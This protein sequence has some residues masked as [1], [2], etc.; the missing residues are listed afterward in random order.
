VRSGGRLVGPAAMGWRRGFGGPFAGFVGLGSWKGSAGGVLSPDLV[1]WVERAGWVRPVRGR[2]ARR[3][4]GQTGN[5]VEVLVLVGS[6]IE[7]MGGYSVDSWLGDADTGVD[8]IA[9]TGGPVVA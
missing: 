1:G 9:G 3:R 8:K 6:G 5:R 4:M 7:E 2:G